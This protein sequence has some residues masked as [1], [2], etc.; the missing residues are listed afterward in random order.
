MKLQKSILKYLKCTAKI[1]S[2]WLV[3]KSTINEEEYDN[4]M[5]GT[6]ET[7]IVWNLTKEKTHATD[8][9]C[10]CVTGLYDFYNVCVFFIFKRGLA[11]ELTFLKS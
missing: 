4:V 2:Q 7:W 10:A 1:A 5:Y 8:I 3:I 11:T 9:T 6:T